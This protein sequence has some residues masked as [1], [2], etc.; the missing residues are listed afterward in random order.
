MKSL[1][2]IFLLTAGT[3][4][5]ATNVNISFTQQHSSSAPKHV[6]SRNHH[7][8]LTTF[9]AGEQLRTDDQSVRFAKIQLDD[10]KDDSDL[11]QQ[12]STVNYRSGN[13]PNVERSGFVNHG[14]QQTHNQFRKYTPQ[15]KQNLEF[16]RYIQSYHSGPTVE[17]VSYF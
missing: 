12:V 10:K 8:Q 9:S 4:L 3:T 17:T 11:K 14:D 5:D 6:E 13:I 1:V 16:E 7:V 15:D 2:L